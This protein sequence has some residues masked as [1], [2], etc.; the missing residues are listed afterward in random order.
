MIGHSDPRTTKSIYGHLF[1]DSSEK[2]AAKLGRLPQCHGGRGV[3]E[4][5]VS[6]CGTGP[7][8]AGT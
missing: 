8:L 1:P 6:V 2:V 3:T 7:L 5:R 4:L